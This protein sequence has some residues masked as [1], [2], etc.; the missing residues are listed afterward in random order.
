MRCFT[1]ECRL[2]RSTPTS[3]T[4]SQTREGVVAAGGDELQDV[5]EAHTAGDVA[6][7]GRSSA[8]TVTPTASALPSERARVTTSTGRSGGENLSAFSSRLASARCSCAGSVRNSGRSGVIV[9]RT[10][11]DP[12]ASARAASITSHRSTQ[13]ARGDAP[14]D[15]S[16]ERSSRSVTS[17]ARRALWWRMVSSS[18]RSSSAS[19]AR[20]RPSTAAEMAASGERKSCET[21]RR[22]AV[23][24]S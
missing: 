21:A 8:G 22:S 14:P 20:P 7:Q 2:D 4:C 3:R 15:S 24:R 12:A 11:S 17:L 1:P 13:S 16:F 9:T 19:S 6:A 18:S 10:R 23:V 5:G